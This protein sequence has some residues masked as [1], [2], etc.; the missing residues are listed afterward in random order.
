MNSTSLD[1]RKKSFENTQPAP[2]H[3][4]G[5]SKGNIHF[6]DFFTFFLKLGTAEGVFCYEK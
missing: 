2:S 4:Y 6:S 3:I 1:V 5:A